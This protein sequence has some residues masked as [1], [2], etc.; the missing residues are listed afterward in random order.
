MA[1]DILPFLIFGA[2]FVAIFKGSDFVVGASLK[3]S[4]YF[5]VSKLTVGVIFLTLAAS[6]PELFIIIF[7]AAKGETNLPVGNALGAPLLDVTLVLALILLYAGD[8]VV[9]SRESLR[10]IQIFFGVAMV[11]LLLL[12]FGGLPRLLGFALLAFFVFY[13]YNLYRKEKAVTLKVATEEKREAIFEEKEKMESE[14]AAL[15][16]AENRRRRGALIIAEF[17]GGAILLGVAGNFLVESAISITELFGLGTMFVGA[18]LISLCTELSDISLGLRAAKRKEYTLALAG[19]FGGGITDLSLNLGL[20]GVLAP[21]K[22]AITGIATIVPFLLMSV[23]LVWYLLSVYGKIPRV[24]GPV[25]LGLYSG[26][27]ME[28]TGFTVALGIAGII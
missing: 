13:M 14:G 16:T 24:Y 15:P 3:M 10:F 7:S 20:I 22:V 21:A 1:I 12:V 2:A 23:L 6:L 19:V 26:F 8:I 28:I 25:F 27:I 18:T 5:R 4:E 9:E 17:L 11:P